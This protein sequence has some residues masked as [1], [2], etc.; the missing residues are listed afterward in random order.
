MR[1]ELTDEDRQTLSA[2]VRKSS[3]EQRQVRRARIVLA[4]ADGHGVSR[5]ARE[6]GVDENTV[7]LWRT[8]FAEGGTKALE[9][10]APRPGRPRTIPAER[11]QTVLTLT[12]MTTP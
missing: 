5:V 9:S 11:V 10:D 2:W 7:R 6:V 8:R 4:L 1:I 12:R 3:G